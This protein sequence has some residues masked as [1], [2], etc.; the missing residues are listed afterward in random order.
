MTP[1]APERSAK[2]Q[3][4]KQ[5][6]H[7]NQ[8]WNQWSAENLQW[9]LDNAE[10]NAEA[11]I[12]DVATGGGFTA[13]AFAP[14]VREVVALDV[15]V[16]M[17]EQARRRAEAEGVSNIVFAEGAAEAM[18]FP[19]ARFDGVTCRIAAH[20][21][22][23]VPQFLSETFRVLKSGGTL[24][25]TDTSVPDNA[26]EA[27]IWQNSIE[28]VRD[29]SHVRNSTPNQWRAFVEATG[30][31]V[32]TI[33]DQNGGVP[34]KMQDW[35][36]KSGCTPEQTA[37]VRRHLETAPESIVREFQIEVLPEGDIAFVWQRVVLKATKP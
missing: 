13:L 30:F 24:L 9:L 23:S 8:Q 19:D 6:A 10:W 36:I 14:F 37:E 25:L 32:E 21:F 34:I 26:P 16:G 17:L 11:S 5:A 31:V 35:C 2:A 20:H 15:S 7:Y 12:L 29:P 27:D 33:S 18:P 28:A 22:L 4:D 3:F 1:F